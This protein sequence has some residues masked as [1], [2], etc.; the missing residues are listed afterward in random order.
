MMFYSGQQF[1]ERFRNQI[2]IPEHGSWNRSKAAGHTGYRI[3]LAHQEENGS[4]SYETFIDGWLDNNKSWGRPVH[5]LQLPD[6][7]ILVSD[8]SADVIYRVTYDS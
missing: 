7:S 6:G 3:T 2:L 8:D 1:P 4:L 5:I